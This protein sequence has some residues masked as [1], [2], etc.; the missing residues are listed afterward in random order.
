ADTLIKAARQDFMPKFKNLEDRSESIRLQEAAASFSA[1]LRNAPYI[2]LSPEALKDTN[3]ALLAK[4]KEMRAIFLTIRF[5][6]FM[7]NGENLNNFRKDYK[8]RSKYYADQAQGALYAY[9][10]DHMDAET[11]NE[12]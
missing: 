1:T 6:K 4:A 12:K 10:L 7:E 11:K 3:A 5:G 8:D 9:F 2:K